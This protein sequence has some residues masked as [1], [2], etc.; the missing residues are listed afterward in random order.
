L[1]ASVLA[2]SFWDHKVGCAEV[3]RLLKHEPEKKNLERG[4]FGERDD[5]VRII[6][7]WIGYKDM[8]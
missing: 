7:M 2:K 5:D 4:H 8:H 6:L 3:T 1:I